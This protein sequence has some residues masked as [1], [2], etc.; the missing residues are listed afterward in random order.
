MIEGARGAPLG[1]QAAL[2]IRIARHLRMQELDGDV[3][4]EAR[5]PRFEHFPHAAGAD[6]LDNAIWPDLFARRETLDGSPPP[7]RKPSVAGG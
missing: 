7:P 1:D 4:F 2:A 5:I 6:A 3:A